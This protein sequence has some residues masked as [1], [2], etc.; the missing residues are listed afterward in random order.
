[1]GNFSKY[2]QTSILISVV[3]IFIAVVYPFFIDNVVYSG[4]AKEADSVLK[5]V[6]SVQEDAYTKFQ[7]YKSTQKDGNSYF[8]KAFNYN[9]SDLQYYDY[10]IKTGI[11]SYTLIAIPKKEYISKR[12]IEPKVLM[13]TKSADGS[14]TAKW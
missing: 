14:E 6:K 9:T 3:A 10:I 7:K 1:M 2:T 13:Y 8:A 12:E 4:K 11:N 5:Q